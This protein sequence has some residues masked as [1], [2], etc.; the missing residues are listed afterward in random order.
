M[1][2]TANGG[3]KYWRKPLD[4]DK[5]KPAEYEVHILEERCK[6]CRF[7]IDFCPRQVLRDADELNAKGY[8]PAAVDPDQECVNCGYCELICP[9]FAISVA[10][11]VREAAG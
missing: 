3:M 1:P 8:R 6:G 4:G 7:C 9:D 11:H 10:P 5:V 2:V